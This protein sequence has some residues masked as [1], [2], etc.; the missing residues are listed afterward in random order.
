[1]SVI[2]TVPSVS[3]LLDCNT[4]CRR[5]NSNTTRKFSQRILIL[6]FIMFI[7]W[8]TLSTDLKFLNDPRVIRFIPS[9]AV[10]SVVHGMNRITLA[11][12]RGARDGA[13]ACQT[14]NPQACQ[15]WISA[16]IIRESQGPRGPAKAFFLGKLLVL[17]DQ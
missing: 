17:H 14:R 12:F 7:P 16:W 10:T 9:T 11:S 4:H 15:T 6:L 2:Y 3:S 8:T 1:M 13:K 5:C